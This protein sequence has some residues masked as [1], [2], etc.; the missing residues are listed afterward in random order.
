MSARQQEF[1]SFAYDT[2]AL[3]FGE[4][5]LNSGRTSPYFYNSA[6]FCD[7]SSLA[8]LADF[9]ARS[10]ME[11][12]HGNYMLFGPAYKG[13]TLV[14]ATA[15][16]LGRAGVA[17]VPYAFNRKEA[18]DHGDEGWL[19]G[20]PIQGEVAI[21]EDVITSGLSIGNAAKLI[22]S[23]HADPVAAVIS[24]DRSEVGVDADETAAQQVR[25]QYGIQV[26]ALATIYDL[27]E[28]V[29]NQPDLR[30]NAVQIREYMD[31]YAA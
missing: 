24:L 21:V 20:A 19:V 4:F 10:I 23:R 11:F 31:Q 6:A 9:Y 17:S 7:G 5:T 12:M 3:I 28:F 18:K 26:H 16:A 8:K 29:K 15:M 14:A 25:S 30:H 1:L 13:I 22:R 27:L 2:G